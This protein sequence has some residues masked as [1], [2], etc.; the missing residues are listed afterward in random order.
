MRPLFEK[1]D[2]P[3]DPAC[4]ES[5]EFDLVDVGKHDRFGQRFAT[6]NGENQVREYFSVYKRLF[7]T[8]M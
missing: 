3:R 8:T 5:S 7:L 6:E 1:F 4:Y 2:D